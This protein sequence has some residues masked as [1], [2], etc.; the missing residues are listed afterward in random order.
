M[1]LI[2]SAIVLLL[3]GL[4]PLCQ[5]RA[6]QPST[7]RQL[8]A[9]ATRVG[10]TFWVVPLNDRLPNFQS[11]AA[12]N[13]PLFQPKANEA[14]DIVEVVGG[15]GTPPLYKVKFESGRDG[16]IRPDM[17]HEE[18]N[19]TIVTEDPL[20]AAREK[21]EKTAQEEKERLAWI[22]AQP[23]SAALKDA[24]I[25]RKPVPGLSSAEVRKIMGIP[26]RVMKYGPTSGTG[27]VGARQREER[28]TY[29]D[30]MLLVFTNGML[31]RVEEKP[32]A[33]K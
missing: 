4:W 18:L 31:A 20:A 14:F 33:Q 30:G 17:F 5:A 22:N 24:A 3:L 6:A 13:A 15:K 8:E 10:K 1:R 7:E 25:K 23:W 29:P 9:L 19:V 21:Q 27:A 26:S 28:W 32:P 2:N 12:A 11:S 16:Y